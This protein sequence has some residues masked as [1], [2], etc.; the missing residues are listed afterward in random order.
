MFFYSEYEMEYRIGNNTEV[1][2]NNR[3]ALYVK[4]HLY[5]IYTFSAS[6]A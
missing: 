3:V 1:L 4:P 6:Y 5:S 2:K